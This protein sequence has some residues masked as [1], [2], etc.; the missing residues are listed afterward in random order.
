MSCRAAGWGASG[1]L[2]RRDGLAALAGPLSGCACRAK[3]TRL[4]EAVPPAE[5]CLPRATALPGW[6]PPELGVPADDN[7]PGWPP[8]CP[9]SCRRLPSFILA[10]PAAGRLEPCETPRQ[11]RRAVAAPGAERSEAASARLPPALLH[12]PGRAL[13][14]PSYQQTGPTRGSQQR[15]VTLR[16]TIAAMR[17]SLVG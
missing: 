4:G 11:G 9:M 12:L 10:P 3:L 13:C 7:R 16:R 14:T 8:S 17:R 2:R 5:G 6:L 1:R 15:G